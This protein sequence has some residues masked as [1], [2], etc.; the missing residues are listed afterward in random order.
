MPYNRCEVNG[1]SGLCM[2]SE[3]YLSRFY[4]HKVFSFKPHFPVKFALNFLHSRMH[5][6]RRLHCG[7]R[8]CVLDY[9]QRGAVSINEYCSELFELWGFNF[10]YMCELQQHDNAA[11]V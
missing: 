7:C 5:T 10:C 4:L 1:I 11:G 8:Q 9:Q 3:Y 2:D 6:G